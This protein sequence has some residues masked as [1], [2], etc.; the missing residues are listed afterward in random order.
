MRIL[1]HQI[2]K[3]MMMYLRLIPPKYIAGVWTTLV[4]ST[5][6]QIWINLSNLWL[7]AA[8]LHVQALLSI[9]SAGGITS[10]HTWSQ[11]QLICHWNCLKVGNPQY[12]WYKFMVNTCIAMGIT[13]MDRQMCLI[14]SKV[15]VQ[16]QLKL[17][18]EQ[19]IHVHCTSWYL[20]LYFVGV[21]MFIIR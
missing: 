6:Q 9:L 10:S 11:S 16:H 8:F 17:W 2:L 19:D 15:V 3:M 5:S 12:A 4:N 1:L 20:R 21:P 18:W 14:N 7:Q 13:N